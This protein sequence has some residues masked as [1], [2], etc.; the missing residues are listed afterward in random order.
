MGVKLWWTPPHFTPPCIPCG[1]LGQVPL[2]LPLPSR[3]PHPLLPHPRLLQGTMKQAMPAP[4][5]MDTPLPHPR[6][7]K[8]KR[9]TPTA[10]PS[11]VEKCTKADPKVASLIPHLPHPH[12]KAVQIWVPHFMAHIPPLEFPHLRNLLWNHHR[13]K[14]KTIKVVRFLS[15]IWCGDGGLFYSYLHPDAFFNS[16]QFIGK[17]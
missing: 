13:P 2:P 10:A 3:L 6:K 8:S 16:S 4:T 1:L 9:A 7:W 12:F 14:A 15:I 5:I 17:H 11:A